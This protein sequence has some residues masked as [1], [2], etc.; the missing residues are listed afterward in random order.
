MDQWI[1]SRL[2][3]CIRTSRESYSE[4]NFSSACNTIHSFVLHEFCDVYLEVIKPDM[5]YKVC[6]NFLSFIHF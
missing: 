2:N 4:Y 5:F 6:S 1:L 3:N